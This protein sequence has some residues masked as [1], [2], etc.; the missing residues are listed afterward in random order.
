MYNV[1]CTAGTFPADLCMYT[2]MNHK[3]QNV[4]ISNLSVRLWLRGINAVENTKNNLNFVLLVLCSL[5]F[6]FFLVYVDFRQFFFFLF[7]VLIS[8][9]MV[10]FCCFQDLNAYKYVTTRQ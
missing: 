3:N 8:S 5:A 1:H 2:W 6:K 9:F 7:K 10:Q 4:K